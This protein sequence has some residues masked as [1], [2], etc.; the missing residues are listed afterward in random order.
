MRTRFMVTVGENEKY[1][2]QDWNVKL[3]EEDVCR[4]YVSL[5]HIVHK[6]KTHRETSVFNFTVIVLAC[7][8]ARI[9]DKFELRG[10]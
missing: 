8:H 10:V 4:L 7:P 6:F 1:I 9:D 3:T 5:S 2:L